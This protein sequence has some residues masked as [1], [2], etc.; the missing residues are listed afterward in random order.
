[1]VPDYEGPGSAYTGGVKAAH[2]VLDGITATESYNPAGLA[3]VSTPVALWGYSGGA[4]AT[5]WSVE[6][7]PT[8]APSLNL[9]G[10]AAGG[11]LVIVASIANTVNNGAFAGIYLAGIVGLSRAYPQLAT[12]LGQYLTPAGQAAVDQVSR[13]CNGTIVT[14]YSFHNINQYST[15]SNPLNLPVARQVIAADPLGRRVPTMPLDV[16]RAVNDEI[17]PSPTVDALVS[18]YCAAGATVVYQRDLLGDHVS[19]VATGES[20]ALVWLPNRLT[21]G[22]TAPTGCTATTTLSTLGSPAA[23]GELTTY[24]AGLIPLFF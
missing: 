9:K 6:L 19:L 10:A 13:E 16:Y 20:A 23:L 18:G 12:L 8:Y 1:M 21:P 3:G 24:L 17:I 7:A 11:V 22:A 15:V 4:L 2:A 5:T 14:Q